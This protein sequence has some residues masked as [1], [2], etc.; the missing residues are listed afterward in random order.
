MILLN[1]VV[2][3]SRAIGFVIQ[4]LRKRT[5]HFTECPVMHQSPRTSTGGKMT[6]IEVIHSRRRAI[7]PL[8]SDDIFKEK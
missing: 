8:A 4:H 7:G 6:A 5:A 2:E 1:Q 3:R